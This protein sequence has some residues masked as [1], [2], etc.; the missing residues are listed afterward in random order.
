MRRVLF[1]AHTFPPMGGAG[2]QRN[3]KFVKYLPEFGYAPSVVTGVGSGA[4]R[5]TPSDQ[6]LVSEIP[7]E[8]TVTR[9][10]G[11]EPGLST[12]WRRRSERWLRVRSPFARWWREGAV[13]TGLALE[14]GADLVYASITPFESGEA[15]ARL[16]GRL[17]C[18]WVLDLRDPWALDEM[19][20]YPTGLHRRAELRRMRG[21]LE[22]ADAVVMNTPESV[23]L[24]GERFGDLGEKPVVAIPNGFDAADFAA[25]PLSPDGGA[26]RIVHTGYLHTGLGRSQRR[27]T[28]ARRLLGGAVKGVD[29]LTR[30]HVFL[31]EALESLVRRDPSLASAVEI[32]LAGVLSESDREAS[33]SGPVRALG[34][35]PHRETIDLLRSANLLFLPMQ[36]LPEGVRAT[37]VPGKT[38]EYLASGRP[39]LAAVP[40]GD[41][42][43]LLREAGNAHV[44][45]PDDVAGMA[46]AI[47]LEVERWRTGASVPAPDPDVVARYERR[48]LTGELAALF[49]A[50][51]AERS[52]AGGARSVAALV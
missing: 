2:V 35:L 50:V 16:G 20:V 42:R 32:H 14:P 18:P 52:V 6:T 51:C 24:V 49:D 38:Y 48:R 27:T 47:A 11:P 31:L 43:D 8:A 37:I 29:I 45:R 34:Y 40:D 19:M 30:S 1:L 21:L 15:A 44:C 41:A 33:G 22:A 17:G 25:P 3:A 12:G 13:A 36:N 5:W 10:A 26:F 7:P 39:I 9:L 46:R 28:R 4:A 23:R